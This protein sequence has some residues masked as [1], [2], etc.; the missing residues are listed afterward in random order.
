MNIKDYT[1]RI[2]SKL[3]ATQAR[4]TDISAIDLCKVHYEMGK[5]LGYELLEEFEITEIEIPH[6]QGLGKGFEIINKKEIIILAMMRSGLYAAEGI[7]SLLTD[8]ALILENNDIETLVKKHIFKEKTIIIVDAVINT[9]KTINNIIHKLKLCECTKI[10]V[11]TLVLQ[12][13]AAL[14]FE[15]SNININLYA[16][17]ISENKYIGKGT[18]D[19]GNRLFN[20]F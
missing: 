18:T 15:E 7:R 4:R 13:E 12:N 1:N 6:V 20:T 14:N 11:V 10:V 17:R 2:A 9:G 8:A 5:F 19:T 3:L 16:L